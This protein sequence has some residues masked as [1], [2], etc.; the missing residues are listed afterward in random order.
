MAKR[1]V[2]VIVRGIVQGVGYRYF[3]LKRGNN[4]GFGG[5]VRNLP[6]GNVEVYAEGEDFSLTGFLG[7]LEEGPMS[8][9]VDE[10]EVHWGDFSG[11]FNDFSVRF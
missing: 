1:A 11:H 2:H 8:S 4:Y 7:E 6:D 3:T 9:R 10:L 5:W